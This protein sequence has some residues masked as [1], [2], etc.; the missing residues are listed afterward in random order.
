MKSDSRE[1]SEVEDFVRLEEAL[2]LGFRGFGRVR[3]VAYITHFRFGVLE[4][5]VTADRAG[6]RL[7]RV[8]GSEQI[9]DAADHVFTLESEGDDRSFLHEAADCREEWH[10]GDVRVM[11]GEDFIAEEHHLDAANQKTFRLETGEDLAGDVF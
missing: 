10:S 4:T 1:V 9:T 5:E 6:R 2:D 8:G 3:S 7:G 11:L